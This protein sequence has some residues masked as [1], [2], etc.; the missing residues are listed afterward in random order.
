MRER[1]FLSTIR[2]AKLKAQMDGIL[3]MPR[4]P[5]AEFRCLTFRMVWA[6]QVF[7][8][9]KVFLHGFFAVLKSQLAATG[10]IFRVKHLEQTFLLWSAL[11]T[12]AA[13]WTSAVRS[14]PLQFPLA[15]TRTD[16]MASADGIFVAGWSAKSPED[17]RLGNFQWFMFELDPAFFP[18]EKS[19]PNRMISA[20][21]A[22]GVALAIA[23]FGGVLVES[24]S[25]VTVLASE[26]W[27]SPSANL[28]LAMRMILQAACKWRFR[29][30][31]KHVA[32][33]DNAL[34]DA[35]SRMHIDS[36]ARALLAD[37]PA[38]LRVPTEVFTD[39]LPEL[40]G[41]LSIPSPRCA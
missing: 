20:A 2:L 21:E 10:Y 26:K 28:A 36:S 14:A 16:A 23:A 13:T 29:P 41:Y 33:K 19:S 25:M 18:S 24:D 6:C 34:A 7:S 38:A 15:V 5:I 3:D 1:V 30:V 11:I 40:K 17:L 8:M 4:V 9:A 39:A 31:V 27:Y 37:L 35:L 32:G 22:I 12:A